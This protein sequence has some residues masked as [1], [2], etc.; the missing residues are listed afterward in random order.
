MEEIFQERVRWDILFYLTTF[1]AKLGLFETAYF[2]TEGGLSGMLQ[3]SF[4]GE[5]VMQ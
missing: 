5:E 3:A 1:E 2:F 4:F